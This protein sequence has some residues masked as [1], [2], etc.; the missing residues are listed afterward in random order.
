MVVW[1]VEGLGK[2]QINAIFVIAQITIHLI[3]N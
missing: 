3:S 2:T 1:V